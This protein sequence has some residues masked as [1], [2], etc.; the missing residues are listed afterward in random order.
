MTTFVYN[1]FGGDIFIFDAASTFNKIDVIKDFNTVNGDAIKIAD[2]LIGYTSGVSDI[3]NYCSVSMSGSNT[4]LYVD[5]AGTGSTYTFRQ[6][7]TLHNVT[8]LDVDTLLFNNN[9][10]AS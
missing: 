9:L 4:S 7:A 1:A 10:M 2:L 5:R 8:G 3:D 6:I